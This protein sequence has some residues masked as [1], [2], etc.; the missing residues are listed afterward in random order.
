[1]PVNTKSWMLF[2]EGCVSEKSVH[3]PMLC[4]AFEKL[5]QYLPLVVHAPEVHVGCWSVG[6]WGVVGLW[7]AGGVQLQRVIH[8]RLPTLHRQGIQF[9]S[10]GDRVCSRINEDRNT[11][12]NQLEEKKLLNFI[13]H[14]NSGLH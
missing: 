10:R 4:I 3:H 7:I 6:R 5:W 1:M 14:D 8:C 9:N 12:T 13:I 11:V 2:I